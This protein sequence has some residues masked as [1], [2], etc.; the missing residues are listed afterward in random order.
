MQEPSQPSRVSRCRVSLLD[1]DFA[2]R[3]QQ[4]NTRT[5]GLARSIWFRRASRRG[6]AARQLQEYRDSARHLSREFKFNCSVGSN[7]CHRRCII[8]LVQ[9]IEALPSSSKIAA[10]ALNRWLWSLSCLT[11]VGEMRRGFS[12]FDKLSLLKAWMG[13]WRVLCVAALAACDLLH[14]WR[15]SRAGCLLMEAEQERMERCLKRSYLK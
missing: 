6:K 7:R 12:Q 15:A 8:D 2:T 3:W 10:A 1:V 5:F 11:S 4:R 9:L 14:P 13:W